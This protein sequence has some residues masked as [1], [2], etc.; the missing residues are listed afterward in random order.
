MSETERR[1]PARTDWVYVHQNQRPIETCPTRADKVG[2]GCTNPW[3][4]LP[5]LGMIS[6][7]RNTTVRIVSV[8]AVIFLP[9]TLI[10]SV[11]DKTFARMPDLALYWG[12]PF[13]LGLMLVSATGTTLSF[14]WKRWKRS[15]SRS[16]PNPLPCRR[17]FRP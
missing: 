17:A 11:Y 3:R 15:G 16:C 12:Y 10:A 8:V 6:V 1:R 4:L 5:S 13:A 14:S 2:P 7:A 9:P